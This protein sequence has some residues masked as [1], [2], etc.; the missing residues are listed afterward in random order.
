M[1][2]KKKERGSCEKAWEMHYNPSPVGNNKPEGAYLPKRS[3][4][5]PTPYNKI[6]ETDH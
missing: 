6:N 1:K 4:D 5:R 2:Y 3:K